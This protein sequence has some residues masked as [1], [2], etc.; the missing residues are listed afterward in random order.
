MSFENIQMK[1]YHLK[2]F[3]LIIIMAATKNYLSGPCFSV[4]QTDKVFK[5]IV[6]INRSF[7]HDL[8]KYSLELPLIFKII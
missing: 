4:S 8:P 6:A 5:E 2:N 1:I 7:V 3:I